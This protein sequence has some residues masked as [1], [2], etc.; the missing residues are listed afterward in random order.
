MI[1]RQ[2]K[3]AKIIQINKLNESY[4]IKLFIDH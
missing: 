2:N 3:G 4:T 1:Q